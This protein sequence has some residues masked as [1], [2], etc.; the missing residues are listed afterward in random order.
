MDP[1]RNAPTTRL[2]DRRSQPCLPAVGDGRARIMFATVSTHVFARLRAWSTPQLK[3]SNALLTTS[4]R[5]QLV[6]KGKGQAEAVRQ[7]D[8]AIALDTP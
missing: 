3:M 5:A 7:E 8:A 4:W 2:A 6:S 1:I